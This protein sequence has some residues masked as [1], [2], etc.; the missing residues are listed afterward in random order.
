MAAWLRELQWEGLEG[1]LV[2][3][4]RVWRLGAAGEGGGRLAGYV[5]SEGWLSEVVVAGRG[6]WCRPT[7]AE[8]ADL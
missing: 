6:T 7:R 2:A 1:F 4:W 3:E 5:Q 8:R